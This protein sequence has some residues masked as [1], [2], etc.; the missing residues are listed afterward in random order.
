MLK[1]SRVE[2]RPNREGGPNHEGGPNTLPLPFHC[3]AV[4]DAVALSPSDAPLSDASLSD[5]SVSADHTARLP[6][7]VLQ[8]T[9]SFVWIAT[10]PLTI[11]EMAEWRK[12]EHS[13]NIP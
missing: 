9:S 12:D 6:G 4:G 5:A 1:L 11:D 7:L 13:M 2:G 8:R 10:R 3:F